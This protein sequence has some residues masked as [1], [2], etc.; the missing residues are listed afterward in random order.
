[1]SRPVGSK[2]RAP[3]EINDYKTINCLLALIEIRKARV[4]KEFVNGNPV[5]TIVSS[6]GTNIGVIGERYKYL[7]DKYMFEHGSGDGLFDGCSQTTAPCKQ[8]GV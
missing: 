3:K 6:S 4:I 5:F 2:N 8:L 7:F 1:M